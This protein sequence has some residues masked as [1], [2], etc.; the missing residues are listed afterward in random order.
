VVFRVKERPLVRTVKVEGTDEIEDEEIEGALKV[1]P[2][3]I[4]DPEKVRQGIEAAKKLYVDKGYLDA[5]IT[6]TTTPV[7]E[8]EVDVLY[9]VEEKG[10]IKV[11]EIEFEGNEAFSSRKL[12]GVMQT[13]EAW[14]F[15]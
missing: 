4:L 2:R 10:T 9:K 3:T 5:T 14:L 1:K 13:R 7:G 8:N 11:E 12:R 6:Y 15:G